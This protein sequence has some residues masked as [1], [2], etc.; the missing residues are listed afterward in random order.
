MFQS[1]DSAPSSTVLGAPVMG[2]IV[3]RSSPLSPTNWH[4][5]SP[6]GSS[7]HKERSVTTVSI[8]S[9]AFWTGFAVTLTQSDSISSPVS[10]WV[11]VMTVS[12]LSV[13]RA[14]VNLHL[15][16]IISCRYIITCWSWTTPGLFCFL[17]LN[18]ADASWRGG[19]SQPWLPLKTHTFILWKLLICL[20]FLL[21]R[22]Y[23]R[24]DQEMECSQARTWTEAH[25]DH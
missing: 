19:L 16:L 25:W 7:L 2:A 5:I 20:I 23:E 11:G 3:H 10:E 8:S 14:S 13:F 21:Q 9:R 18:Q 12:L 24:F 15:Q 1:A 4:K 17:C 22:F 6:F